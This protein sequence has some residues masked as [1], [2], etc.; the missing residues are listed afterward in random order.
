[1]ILRNESSIQ[2]VAMLTGLRMTVCRVHTRFSRSIAAVAVTFV[3]TKVTKSASQ[4]KGFF[5]AQAFR[6]KPGKTRAAIILPGEP[7]ALRPGMQKL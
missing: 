2:N 1:M 3:A 6:R 5:A 4:Q 7:C